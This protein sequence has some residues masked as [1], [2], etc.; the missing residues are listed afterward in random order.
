MLEE[1]ILLVLFFIEIRF[2]FGFVVFLGFLF[3]VWS[4]IN[5]VF[6]IGCVGFCWNDNVKIWDFC[7]VMCCEV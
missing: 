1:V 2:L 6:M 7:Y 4:V 5:F 3:F